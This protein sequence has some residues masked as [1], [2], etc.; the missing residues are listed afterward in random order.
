MWSFC[1]ADMKYAGLYLSYELF[2][3]GYGYTMITKD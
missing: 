1:I 3:V 2:L